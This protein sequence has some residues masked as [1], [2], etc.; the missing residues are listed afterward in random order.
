MQ[1]EFMFTVLKKQ[2]EYDRGRT[3]GPPTR[4]TPYLAVYLNRNFHALSIHVNF[5]AWKHQSVHTSLLKTCHIRIFIPALRP[6]L[7]RI[8]AIQY[9]IRYLVLYQRYDKMNNTICF[10][11][12]FPLNFISGL[13]TS[14]HEPIQKRTG[15]R[16]LIQFWFYPDL[17]QIIDQQVICYQKRFRFFCNSIKKT[18]T[19][20]NPKSDWKN[21]LSPSIS[22]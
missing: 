10:R 17:R 16:Y 21:L 20:Q 19:K 9:C 8:D 12:S 13:D 6:Q 11:M 14:D 5:I 3:L 1:K 7:S 22:T 2:I 18:K 4:A 15:S